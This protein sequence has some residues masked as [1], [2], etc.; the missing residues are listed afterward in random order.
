LYPVDLRGKKGI[1]LGVANERSIAWGI[2]SILAQAGATLA[3]TYQGERLKERVSRLAGSLE[4]ALVLPCDASDDGQ[5]AELFRRV[6]DA[7]GSSAFL[8]HS[9]A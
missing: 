1:V 7:F 9:I 4:G 5:I 6:G 3:L 2:A 8:V